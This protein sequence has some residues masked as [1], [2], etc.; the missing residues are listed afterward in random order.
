MFSCFIYKYMAFMQRKNKKRQN[1]RIFVVIKA[2]GGF[3]N[4]IFIFIICTSLNIIIYLNYVLFFFYLKILYIYFFLLLNICMPKKNK[5][6]K[7]TF[8]GSVKPRTYFKNK[9][10][11]LKS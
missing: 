6:D 8:K 11:F 1:F 3:K 9:Y 10:I 4:F 7:N 2:L 5:V